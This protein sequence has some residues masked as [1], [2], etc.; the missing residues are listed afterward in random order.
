MNV[1]VSASDR[2]SWEQDHIDGSS[3]S[4]GEEEVRWVGG[5]GGGGRRCRANSKRRFTTSS[6]RK[7]PESDARSVGAGLSGDERF[8]RGP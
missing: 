8:V 5:G 1:S 2:A 7:V 3:Y 6:W 4:D